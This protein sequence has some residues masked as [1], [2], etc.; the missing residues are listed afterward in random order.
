MNTFEVW[1]PRA[2]R[3]E[4]ELGERWIDLDPGP[5]GTYRLLERELPFGTRYRLRLDGGDPR[6]DPRSGYQPE[7]VHGASMRVDHSSF[8]WTDAG[9]TPQPLSRAVIYELH[10]G[11]FT[12]GGRF[13]DVI[14]RLDHLVQLGVTHVELM[15]VVEFPG[16]RGW[17]YD[18]VHLFA[19]HHA[20]GTPDDLKRLVDACHARGL[21]AVLDV[22]YNH[23]G[24][25]GNYLPEFGPFFT[26]QYHTPWGAA[27]NFDG[28]GSD[29]VRRFF[30]D[31]ARQWLEDYHFDGL[32]LDAIHAFIDRSARPFLEQLADEVRA[33]S[34]RLGRPKILIAESDLN[35][36]R[37][38]RS[39]EHGGHGIDA[40]WSDDFHHVLHVL[41]T[42]ERSGYYSDFGGLEDLARALSEGFVYADRR[43][44]FRGRTHGRALGALPLN[45]LLGYL[46]NHDQIGNRAQGDRIGSSLSVEQ[47]ELGAALVLTA[48]FVPMLFQGEEWNASTPFCYFTDHEDPTLADAVRRGRKSEFASFGWK[49]EQIPDP[50]AEE[51]FAASRLRWNE[52][53]ESEHARLLAWYRALI[54]LRASEPA[55]TGDVRPEVTLDRRGCWLSSR[56]GSITVV[57]NFSPEQARVPA[58]GNHQLVLGSAGAV[59]SGEVLELPAWGVGVLR[60]T[61]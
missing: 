54:H 8:A 38:L 36:P 32:R 52:I 58:S 15:P 22:V 6:P 43:S 14:E 53:E 21:A 50:Q 40:Q 55:L 44:A 19:P 7:G 23:L 61:G 47:L 13:V 26:E 1:A 5:N 46:Q 35:D 2:S 30:C 57:A 28:A 27:V 16:A 41:L 3:V 18:G 49:P 59:W 34:K 24:P 56:R 25:D 45:R 33:L 39:A 9:F 37:V 31:N 60:R 42:G 17:G 29:E 51:T 4:I 11:T 20:Y 48:P 10:V 12:P